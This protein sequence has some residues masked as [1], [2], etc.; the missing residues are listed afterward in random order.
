MSD[1]LGATAAPTTS[2]R[3]RLH[4]GNRTRVKICGIT[5]VEDGLAACAAGA[6][7][8]GLVFYAPSPR[9]VAIEAAAAIRQALPPFVTV[10]GLF[11]N[12]SEETVAQIAERVRLDLLQFHGDESPLDCERSGLPYMKAVRVNDN[13]DL[14]EASRRYA[15][16]KALVLDSHDENLWGGSGRTFD[17]E[18]VPLDIE[19]PIVLAG[20]LTTANVADAITRLRPYGV[21]VSGGVEQSPGIKD[22]ARIAK[23]I[24][25]VD[26]VTFAERT[27]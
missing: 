1:G 3:T 21:D 27:G 8:I 11:V 7:A 20:G 13:V 26:R 25:E 19:C 4:A 10:V 9:A 16:A 22:A 2:R 5:R 18:L 6:D 15:N 23:F 24:Q 14:L 17:W 12:E